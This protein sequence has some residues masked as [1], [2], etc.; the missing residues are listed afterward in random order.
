MTVHLLS[1][2]EIGPDPHKFY[3]VAKAPGLLAG[4]SFPHGIEWQSLCAAGYRYVVCLT[5]KTSSQPNDRALAGGDSPTPARSSTGCTA[6]ESN[7]LSSGPRKMTTISSAPLQ[8]RSNSSFCHWDS[9][10]PFHPGYFVRAAFTAFMWSMTRS[11]RK[12]RAFKE[13]AMT[14]PVRPVPPTQ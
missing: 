12:P 14:V 4:M 8:N 7:V 11:G 1:G 2:S 5:D 3:A 6:V 10:Q 13:Q 9:G